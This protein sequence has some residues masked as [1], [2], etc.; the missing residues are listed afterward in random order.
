[1]FYGTCSTIFTRIFACEFV[2]VFWLLTV[3]IKP[4]CS[5]CIFLIAL[6][7]IDD[8]MKGLLIYNKN[9]KVTFAAFE[10]FIKRLIVRKSKLNFKSLNSM[11][12]EYIN[13]NDFAMT[14]YYIVYIIFINTGLFST[15]IFSY[16]AFLHLGFSPLGF[17]PLGFSPLGFSPSTK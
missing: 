14:S 8:G 9:M 6:S 10:I 15:G 11:K 17:S 4:L 2:F 12:F 1:M 16:W 13:P 5:D 7:I 3:V